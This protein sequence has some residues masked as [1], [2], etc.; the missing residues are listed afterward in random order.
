MPPPHSGG[1]PAYW[2]LWAAAIPLLALMGEAKLHVR[3]FTL[4]AFALLGIAAASVAVIAATYRPGLRVTREPFEDGGGESGGDGGP[5][6]GRPR[7]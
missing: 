2:L 1:R 7:D 4:F 3:E 5:D 6:A